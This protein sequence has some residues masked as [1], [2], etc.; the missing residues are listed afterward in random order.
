MLIVQIETIT[1]RKKFKNP[2]A[3]LEL[4]QLSRNQTVQIA[5]LA[6]LIAHM[7]VPVNL[8]AVTIHA[9]IHTIAAI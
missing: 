1:V 7:N 2:Q 9:W 5:T 6:S 8:I 3:Q 4:R